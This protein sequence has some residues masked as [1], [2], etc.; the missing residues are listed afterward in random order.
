MRISIVQQEIKFMKT[1]FFEQYNLSNEKIKEIWESGLVV[2]DTNILLNLYRYNKQTCDDILSYMQTFSDQLWMPYQVGLEY[3]NNRMKVAYESQ[4]ACDIL[5]KKL[6]EDRVAIDNFFKQK[7]H[8]HPYLKHKEFFKRY[9]KYVSLLKSYLQNIRQND[10]SYF[11]NDTIVEKLG[12]LYEGRVGDDFTPEDLKAVYAEGKNRYA[13][14]IPPG[15]KDDTADKRAAGERHLYGD[16]I[17]WKQI[18]KKAADIGKDVIFV[19]DDLKEDWLLEFNGKKYGPRKELIK[20]FHEQTNNHCIL[21]YSQE[22]FL[23]YANERFNAKLKEETITE[24]KTFNQGVLDF[25]KDKIASSILHST[26]ATSSLD[27]YLKSIEAIKPFTGVFATLDSY[28]A[29]TDSLQEQADKMKAI[30]E[31]LSQLSARASQLADI[32]RIYSLAS[33]PGWIPDAKT[34]FFVPH[35]RKENNISSDETDEIVE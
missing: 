21:I 27:A 23:N 20:E 33:V 17:V 16:L 24:V 8:H 1:K 29:F 9:D 7:F 22:C 6:D 19:S 15:Y 13:G 34:G 32:G 4:T 10:N 30:T 14:K 18:I 5:S 25:H 26:M 35:G 31:P 28:K 2:F 3:N 12:E 11:D